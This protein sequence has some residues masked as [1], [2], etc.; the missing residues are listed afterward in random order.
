MSDGC[1]FCA[2]TASCAKKPGPEGVSSCV[3]PIKRG[4]CPLYG[5]CDVCDFSPLELKWMSENGDAT[6]GSLQDSF[7]AMPEVEDDDREEDVA[8]GCN[9]DS[10]E[11]WCERKQKCVQNWVGG[12]DGP[13]NEVAAS[14]TRETR[15]HM[16]NG[17]ISSDVN[18]N[19]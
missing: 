17:F 15:R 5:D 9:V 1:E 14:T 6:I 19:E 2:K 10:R 3:G 13:C 4:H 8:R 7:T 12:I 11:T 18:M 16:F